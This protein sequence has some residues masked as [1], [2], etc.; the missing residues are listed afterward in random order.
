MYMQDC[1]IIALDTE[2][3]VSQDGAVLEAVACMI[4]AKYWLAYAA[5]SES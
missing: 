4:K 2:P 1:Q 5:V 3:A